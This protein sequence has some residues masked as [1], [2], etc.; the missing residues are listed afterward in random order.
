MKNKWTFMRRFAVV[1]LISGLAWASLGA[2]NAEGTG[3][4]RHGGHAMT[5]VAI[6]LSGARKSPATAARSGG[7][8][9]NFT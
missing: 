8:T 3:N 5:S 1:S 9:Q 4:P 2:K 7:W 6:L